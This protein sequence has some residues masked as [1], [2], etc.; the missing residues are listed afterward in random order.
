MA[1]DLGYVLLIGF[2]SMK[3][4]EVYKEVTRR[5]GLYQVAWWKSFVNLCLCAALVLLVTHR[6]VQVKVLIAV[7]AS[8]L[9]AL[10]HALDTVLRSHRDNMITAVMDKTRNRR[11]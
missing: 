8:G 9:A 4:T 11:R 3:L 2:G 5:I 10:L 7:A 6:D 1:T